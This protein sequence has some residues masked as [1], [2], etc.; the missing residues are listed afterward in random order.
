M[1]DSSFAFLSSAVRSG[2]GKVQMRRI[3]WAAFALTAWFSFS[4]RCCA[5][6]HAVSNTNAAQDT[7]AIFFN[8]M[9][10]TTESLRS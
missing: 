10:S 1:P 6:S 2:S 5:L 9:V 7:E 4:L 3:S 8:W